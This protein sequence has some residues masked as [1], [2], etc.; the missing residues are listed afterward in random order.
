MSSKTVQGPLPEGTYYVKS[1]NFFL[2][3]APNRT[4]TTQTTDY[5]WIFSVEGQFNYLKDP[6]TTHYL[7]DN[8]AGNVLNPQPNV[9]GQW[10]DGSVDQYLPPTFY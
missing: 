5:P 3:V 2:S 7:T 9:D 4:I 10:A 1:G 8:G 6:M